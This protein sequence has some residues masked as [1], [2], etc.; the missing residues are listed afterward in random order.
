MKLHLAGDHVI[1]RRHV[2]GICHVRHI[3]VGFHLEQSCRQ[4]GQRATKGRC[5]RDLAWIC[6][7]IG[8]EFWNGLGGERW[9]DHH[10]DGDTHHTRHRRHVANEIEIELVIERGIDRIR[11]VREQERIAIRASMHDRFG[12]DV[13]T[14]PRA[15][16]DIE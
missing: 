3:D 2:R 5:H 8:D 12:R 10:D 1:E 14:V 13:G 15:I 4:M 6:L 9:I 11:R 16:F 7:G